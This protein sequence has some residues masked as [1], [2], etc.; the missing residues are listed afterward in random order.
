MKIVNC[1]SL[2]ALVAG[3]L[4]VAAPAS[5]SP[6]SPASLTASHD[7]LHAVSLP[8]DDGLRGPSSNQQQQQQQQQRRNLVAE[9]GVIYGAPLSGFNV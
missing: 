2:I 6:L 9:A 1:A 8:G 7:M 4:A 3:G 5:A